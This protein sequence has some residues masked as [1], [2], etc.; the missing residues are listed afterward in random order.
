[1]RQSIAKRKEVVSKKEIA[2]L[3]WSKRN[4]DNKFRIEVDQKACEE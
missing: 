3:E 4:R 1:M 2:L